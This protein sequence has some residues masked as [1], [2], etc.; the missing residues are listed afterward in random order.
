MSW[1]QAISSFTSLAPS[2]RGGNFFDKRGNT[3]I[4]DMA[5]PFIT[6]RQ[7]E[8]SVISEHLRQ[9]RSLHIY[10]PEGVGKSAL[11]DC[12]FEH[13]REI[14]SELVPIYCRNSMTLRRLLIDIAVPLLDKY[15][16][17]SGVDKY[18]E[19]VAIKTAKDV[20]KV[21]IINL[22]NIVF[23][24]V[25]KG[26]FCLIFDHLETVTP[27]INSL[28]TSLYEH[29]TV[30]TASRQ[31][32][33]LLDYGFRGNLGFS[34]YLVPKVRL[35]NL[36]KKDAYALME[37]WYD[38]LQIRVK[39]KTAFFH[40]I[41]HITSGNPKVIIDILL[42]AQK[43]EYFKDRICNLNLIHLDLMIQKNYGNDLLKNV[44]NIWKR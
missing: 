15:K 27:K 9:R 12:V 3:G 19:P 16:E 24:Y 30:I 13:F 32:W 40:N 22:R 17:L 23:R 21:N 39:D 14:D 7:K 4:I 43:Q 36:A 1:I 10:G 28:L 41:Y 11:L 38:A 2:L 26:R 8:I 37:Y 20:D 6:G 42:K 18:K 35:E 34:L 29:A 31:S 25:K 33:E 44:L 5:S